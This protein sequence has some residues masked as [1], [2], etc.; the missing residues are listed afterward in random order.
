LEASDG[1]EGLQAAIQHQPDVILLDLAM[2]NMD[3]FEFMVHLQ[4][5]PQTCCIPV[6]VSTASVF[7]ENRQR[8]LQA[9]AKAF[10]TK[11]LQIDELL[12]AL[13]SAFEAAAKLSLLKVDWITE[14]QPQ[15]LSTNH[16]PVENSEL[17]LPSGEILQQLYHL[18][19]MGDIP[20]IEGIIEEL[21]KQ[22]RQ[23]TTFASELRKLTANFQ[24]AKIRKF[25]KTFVTT[26]SHP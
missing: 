12:N 7:E 4:E 14:S 24:T 9:G 22:D 18:A 3:G 19:M 20:T 5:N 6:I 26:Q 21:V 1:K 23:L 2:P 13:R 17:I 15:Q 16:E 25:L 8:S 11:P 10:L